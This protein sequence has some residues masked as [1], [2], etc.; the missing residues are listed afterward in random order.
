MCVAE[1]VGEAAVLLKPGSGKKGSKKMSASG[2]GG[3][4]TSQAS[5]AQQSSG[6]QGGPQSCAHQAF[7][8]FGLGQRSCLGQV[9]V[10]VGELCSMAT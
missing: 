8:P 2:A 4:S 9:F 3:A 10:Q 1:D 7:M 6:E 5:E